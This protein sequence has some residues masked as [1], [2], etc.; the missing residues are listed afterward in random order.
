M[1]NRLEWVNAI[2]IANNVPRR[3][4]GAFPLACAQGVPESVR[5]RSL[6]IVR[7]T[8]TWSL[9]H[10]SLTTEPIAGREVLALVLQYW[11]CNIG[12]AINDRDQIVRSNMKSYGVIK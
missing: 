6:P 2:P 4:G 12:F 9:V 8:G 3:R 10:K 7:F 11:F 5:F 1:D